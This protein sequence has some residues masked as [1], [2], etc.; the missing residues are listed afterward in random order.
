MMSLISSMQ[1]ITPAMALTQGGP[2][3][4]STFINYIMYRYA[5]R[6]NQMGYACALAFIFFI[7]IAVFTG[8]VFASSGKWVFYEG[9]EK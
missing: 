6:N 5:F 8:L 3:T 7:I 1:T 4:S 2:G 9:G